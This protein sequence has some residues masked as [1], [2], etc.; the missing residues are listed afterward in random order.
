MVP[1]KDKLNVRTSLPDAQSKMPVK[2]VKF[3]STF[4]YPKS[5]ASLLYEVIV[6]EIVRLLASGALKRAIIPSV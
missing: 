2:G 3:V 6:L 4:T 5:D 1:G